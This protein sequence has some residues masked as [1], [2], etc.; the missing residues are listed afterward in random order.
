MRKI[1]TIT[2]PTYN[3]ER[4]LRDNLDS[5]CIPEL[6]NDLEILIINDGSIDGSAAIA[7]EYVQ[8]FPETYRVITKENGGHGSGINTGIRYATGKYFKVVDA[9]DW[10]EKEAFIRLVQ[11]LKEKDSDIVSSGFYWVYDE[12]QKN[13]TEFLRKKEMKIPFKDVEYQ[14]EYVFDEIADRIY[15]KMHNM[16]VKTE[17][18]KKHNIKVDEHCYYVD[19]EYITYPIPYVKTICFV[20]EFVYMYRLGRQGQSVSIEKMQYNEKN[21]DRVIASLVG[22]YNRLCDENTCSVEKRNYIARIIAR[23]VA[24]KIKIMLSFP[25]NRQKKKELCDFDIGLKINC[26]D[27]YEKNINSAVGILRR[28]NYMTYNLMS[29]LVRIKYR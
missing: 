12:G 14:K 1:L 20:E 9:D 8:R 2:V 4:Y 19:T 13:K 10:V 29:F 18:L 7:E 27:V 3:A 21:Y 24:G 23:V 15:I 5:F 17:I 22:F 16:T 6:L 26:Q 25:G 11:T 28:S